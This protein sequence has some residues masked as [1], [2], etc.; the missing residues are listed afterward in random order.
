MILKLQKWDRTNLKSKME[1]S[2]L[3]I[4]RVSR[5]FLKKDFFRSW[6]SRFL[7][8]LSI[9]LG[10][11]ALVSLE[12]FSRRISKSISQDTRKFLA[13]DIQIQAF[14]DFEDKVLETAQKL[15]APNGVIRQTDLVTT[16][17]LNNTQA[18][19]VTLRFLEGDYPFYGN[20][21]TD[22]GKG[23]A[24]L[25]QEATAFVDAGLQQNLKLNDFINVGALKVRVIGFIQEEPQTASTFFSLGPK[26]ILHQKWAKDVGLLGPG[27]RALRYLLIKTQLEPNEYR[28]SFRALI[29][30]PHWRVITPDRANIQIQGV[31]NRL[32]SYLSLVALASLFLGAMGVFMMLRS[33]FILRKEQWLSLRCLGLTQK[34]LISI[35]VSQSLALALIGAILGCVMAL[36]IESRLSLMAQEF[37]KIDLSS[38]SIIPSILFGLGVSVLT[39]LASLWGPLREIISWPVAQSIQDQNQEEGLKKKDFIPVFFVALILIFWVARSFTLGIAFLFSIL[40][41]VA[42]LIFLG[43]GLL[44]GLN[45][46]SNSIQGIRRHLF[47]RLTRKA[48]QFRL[49]L[50]SIGIGVFLI[51]LLSVV[52]RSLEGQVDLSKRNEL[53]N[54]YLLSVDGSDRKFIDSIMDKTEWVPVTQARLKDIKGKSIVEARD[55]EVDEQSMLQTREYTITKRNFLSEG[56]RLLK[57]KQMFSEKAE[58]LIRVSIE[59]RFSQRVGLSIGDVFKVSIAGVDLDARVDSVRKVDWW[60]FRPNFFLVFHPDDLAEAPMDFVVFS[61]QDPEK[62]GILQKQILAKLP[63]VSTLNGESL[64]LRF[65]SLISRLSQALYAVGLFTILAAIF[66][67]LGILVSQRESVQQEM[68]LLKC[69]GWGRWPRRMLYLGE[70]SMAAFFSSLIAVGLSL[71]VGFGITKFVLDIDFIWPSSN[72]LSLMLLGPF[73]MYTLLSIPILEATFSFSNRP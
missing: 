27:S 58:N 73:T 12:A 28:K 30:D 45:K 5:F 71:F 20:F 52:S 38:I 4:P 14:R 60:N 19:N 41:I 9:A 59:D 40:L 51:S 34:A 72:L 13:A 69:L 35:V 36:F 33:H 17:F 49:M 3:F 21:S 70:F 15:A 32:S 61:H 42:L 54:F 11:S 10:V 53:P 31:V 46:I 47:L 48:G 50:L 1:N 25:T 43:Q 24:D 65:K 67:F 63:H 8:V 7:V 64:S 16:V 62:I 57:G 56:E 2:R 44:I 18:Q 26:I 66:V 37:Y 29:P 22:T 39:V 6:G 55:N 68:F 23:I